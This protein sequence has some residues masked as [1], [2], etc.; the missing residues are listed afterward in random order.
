MGPYTD[1][2][3]GSGNHW[4]DSYM[5][6]R[7]LIRDLDGRCKLLPLHRRWLK[8]AYAD[9][10]MVAA[11]SMPRGNAK[12]WLIGQLAAQAITPGSPTFQPRTEVI[13]VAASL[14]QA[15]VMLAFAR[16]AIGDREDDYRWLDSGQRLAVTH[17]DTGAKFRILS[18]SGKRALGL[19]NFSTIYADEPSAWEARNGAVMFDALKTALGKRAGQRLLLIGT[20]SPAAV[21]SWWPELLSA[22]SGPGIHVEDLGAEDDEVVALPGRPSGASIR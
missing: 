10:V 3:S 17:K 21:G 18:S 7:R 2:N 14:E 6:A 15:R 20:K 5:H 4:M 9:D 19:E 8:R 11:L 1:R 12:T 16:A 22:G 13:G